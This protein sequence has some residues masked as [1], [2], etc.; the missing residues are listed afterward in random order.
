MSPAH[1][2][3][4]L[5]EPLSLSGHASTFLYP[6]PAS[7]W[8]FFCLLLHIPRNLVSNG[9]ARPVAERNLRS[10]VF[11]LTTPPK[12]PFLQH[13]FYRATFD[14]WQNVKLDRVCQMNRRKLTWEPSGCLRKQDHFS[15]VRTRIYEMQNFWKIGR[16]QTV[17]FRARERYL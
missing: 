12:P 1:N 5:K 6:L 13:D 17:G 9:V 14:L 10:F 4:L 11:R 15:N 8:F 3:G 7:L 16:L 2:N